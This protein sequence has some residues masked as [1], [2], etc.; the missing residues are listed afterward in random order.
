MQTPLRQECG[1]VSFGVLPARPV[2]TGSAIDRVEPKTI[3][4]QELAQGLADETKALLVTELPQLP[5]RYRLFVGMYEPVMLVQ[6]PFTLQM[7]LQETPE[8]SW[9]IYQCTESSRLDEVNIWPHA[10]QF[11]KVL[12]RPYCADRFPQYRKETVQSCHWLNGQR[13]G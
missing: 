10:D 12:P 2:D 5:D 6:R 3:V 11:V 4:S 9:P 8:P 1:G 7:C 13:P